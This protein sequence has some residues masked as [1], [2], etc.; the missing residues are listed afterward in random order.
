MAETIKVCS[1]SPC[2]AVR[3]ILI[4]SVPHICVFASNPLAVF[5]CKWNP[6]LQEGFVHVPQELIHICE[7]VV[8]TDPWALFSWFLKLI[9]KVR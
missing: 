1:Y 4:K 8:A 9:Q 7:G 5:F 6:L 3:Y 2:F